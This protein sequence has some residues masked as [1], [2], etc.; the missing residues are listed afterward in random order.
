[1]F[2]KLVGLWF[3]QGSGSKG[4]WQVETEEQAKELLCTTE[5]F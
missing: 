3:G 2:L 5:Q 1:M 4:N